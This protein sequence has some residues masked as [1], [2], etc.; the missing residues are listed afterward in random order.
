MKLHKLYSN[1][2]NFKDIKF[3]D[4]FNVVLGEISDESRLDNDAHNLGKSTLISLID[5]MLLKELKAGHFLKKNIFKDY[6]FFLEIKLNSGEYVTIRRPVYK[7]TKISLAKHVNEDYDP[8]LFEQWDY[9]DLSLGT[10]DKENNPKEILNKWLKFDVLI[11]EDYR[12]TSGYFLRTQDDYSDVFK[13]QKYRG[14]DS[15]WKPVLFELLGFNSEHMLNKYNIEK[16]ISEKEKLIEEFQ[17]EFKVDSGEKDRINGQ[18]EI[19]EEKR[20]AV[21]QWLDSFDFYQKEINLDKQAVEDVELAIS[22]LN[23]KRFNLEFELQQIEESL[24]VKVNYNLDEVLNL[25]KEVEIH[26]PEQIVKE[27]EELVEFNKKLSN[28]RM[29]YLVEAKE[30]KIAKLADINNALR[31]LNSQRRVLLKNLTETD[32]FNKY[33]AYRDELIEVERELEHY[34]SELEGIDNVKR[35][36]EEIKE[37]ELKLQREKDILSKQIDESAEIYKN[38]RKDFHE[39]VLEILDSNAM[40]ALDLNNRGNVDFKTFFYNMEDE[41]TAQGYGHTYRKLLC[42]CFDLAIIKNYINK[43]FFRFIYHDGCLESLDPRKQK[44][45]LSLVRRISQENDIQYVLTCLSSE[46]PH[47][48][49]YK[50]KDSE[51]AIKLTDAK[52]DSGRLFGFA[53]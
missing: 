47:G 41:E 6:V 35:I 4:E 34:L 45:Y 10:Q 12:K 32:T 40:I 13:L 44:K 7:N 49:A 52:D 46:I 25:Y 39:F 2:S 3:N 16:E 15:D 27:Y 31:D 21:R 23:T 53:F 22:K 5:F 28:E 9:V 36:E 26:F 14:A 43:S 48:D 42:A 8:R 29:K 1:K 37:L 51:L 30:K 24:K 11:G 17:R 33:N 50:I 19:A 18:I 20:K 38:I